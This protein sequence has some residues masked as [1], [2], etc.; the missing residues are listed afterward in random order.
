MGEIVWLCRYPVKS[1]LGEERACLGLRGSGVEGDRRYALIDRET[2]L[3]ASAKY[4][5]RWRALLRLRSWYDHGRLAV[6]LPDGT[7]H[8]EGAPS[9]DEALS[10]AA[11]R[12][13]RLTRERPQGAQLE[14][15]SPLVEADAGTVVRS[16]LTNQDSFVDFGAL[17][18][19]TTATLDALGGA[20][21]RRFRPNV[22]LRM[23][24]PVP[25]VENGWT[26]H[27]LST[28]DGTTLRVQVPTPRCQVPT[29]AHGPDLPPDV[30]VLR[31]A[32]RQNR[33]PVLQLGPLTCVGAYAAVA[34]LGRLRIGDRVLV[35]PR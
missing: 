27:T 8:H 4:P 35:S 29:L 11:G 26:A 34:D 16:T 24:E 9:L 2:G 7:T 31:A 25:F 22:V 32:A 21:P 14:R 3:V 20:D 1:L 23:R 17:H 19:V 33:V 18:L 6:T 10:R 15:E 12:A 30:E 28:E 13:V 5:R